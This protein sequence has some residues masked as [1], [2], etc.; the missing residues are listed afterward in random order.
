MPELS[1][2][3]FSTTEPSLDTEI[4]F[5]KHAGTPIKDLSIGMVEWL[6]NKCDHG[7]VDDHRELL[8]SRLTYI[9][10][11]TLPTYELAEDQQ[12]ASDEIC[13]SL[14]E[15][16]NPIHRL[17]GGAGYGKSF[18]VQDVVIRAKQ[19]G[20]Q[21]K[22]CATSYVATQNLA[23]DLDPLGVS[24]GTIARTL[25]LDVTYQG[26]REN[27]EAGTDTQVVIPEILGEGQLLIVDEYS[28]VD[29]QIANILTTG[30]QIYGGRLL[31]VGDVYQ[32]PSPA[33]NW[34]SALSL[35]EP[36]SELTIPKRYSPDSDLFKVEQCVRHD[37][38][39]FD[40]NAY[41]TMM[42]DQVFKA[43]SSAALIE[44]YVDTFNE[45][46]D[47]ESLMIWY[48]RADMASSNQLIRAKLFSEDAPDVCEG[49]QLR[50][51]RTSDYTEEFMGDGNRVYSGTTLKAVSVSE[52]VREIYIEEMDEDFSIPVTW[53]TDTN[54]KKFAVLFSITETKASED[55]RG[56]EEFNKALKHISDWCAENNQWS[57]QRAFRNCFV[58]VAYQYAST[59]HR[60]QGM[61]V[62]NVFT[63]PTALRMADPFTANKLC[64]VG[65]TR[66]K[67][68]LVC[69]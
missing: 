37:P 52:G 35:I 54:G 43:D 40:V 15:V 20:Y 39:K 23:K 12:I 25:R 51:Q 27:Y 58:Q 1:F 13:H 22:A 60:V 63:S 10:P 57:I 30:V 48:R 47:Q 18:A 14:F 42:S 8:E 44:S 33:Q 66:A 38:S 2:L 45:N 16:N 59:V 68:K 6:L 26:A 50:V 21:V 49:E 46:P 61:S 7:W 9:D 3:D 41:K 5:T 69:L 34:D 36:S 53:I 28:M 55:K 32:L 65:L 4:P 19:K 29:D 64:Y 62:D 67:N 56:G 31:V 24:C 11:N 17:Q